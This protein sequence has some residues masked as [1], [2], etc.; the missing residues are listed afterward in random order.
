MY[1]SIMNIA[2]QLKKEHALA[3]GLWQGI[4]MAYLLVDTK[5]RAISTNQATLDM[6]EIDGTVQASLGKTLAELFLQRTRA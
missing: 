5:E 3:T 6:L 1:E 4:P 2:G